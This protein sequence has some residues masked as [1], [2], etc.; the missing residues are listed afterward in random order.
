[1]N[2]WGRYR[3]TLEIGA[4]Y[5]RCKLE[6]GRSSMTAKLTVMIEA[7]LGLGDLTR[8]TALIG[9]LIGLLGSVTHAAEQAAPR[10]VIASYYLVCGEPDRARHFLDEALTTLSTAQPPL[11]S[12]FTPL[13]ILLAEA[14]R[15][16]GNTTTARRTLCDIL[17]HPRGCSDF[18]HTFA[19]PLCAALIAA[20][21]GDTEASQGLI[22]RWN[23][24]RRTHGLPV[25][26]GFVAPAKTVNLDPAPSDHPAK[27]W[28]PT[29]LTACLDAARTWCAQPGLVHLPG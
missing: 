21:L 25:P 4:A 11:T 23:R 27:V 26:V 12:R 3:R 15:Q 1:M 28:N 7:L 13:Q 2:T 29:A 14:Q 24:T 9:D 16:C 5:D 10:R 6:L 20:D 19:A 22:T 18:K 8:A 17:P